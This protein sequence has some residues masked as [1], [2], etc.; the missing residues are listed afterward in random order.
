MLKREAGRDQTCHF[1]AAAVDL[2]LE[3]RSPLCALMKHGGSNLPEQE[4]KNALALLGIT[5]TFSSSLLLFPSSSQYPQSWASPAAVTSTPTP[6]QNCSSDR[7]HGLRLCSPCYQ[8]ATQCQHLPWYKT[9]SGDSPVCLYQICCFTK[10][11]RCCNPPRARHKA[12]RVLCQQRGDR[13][14][15][16]LQ[17]K[18]LR[19]P[20][21]VKTQPGN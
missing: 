18:V 15:G 8:A 21:V 4:G 7:V 3:M 11:S 9:T 14:A 16:S 2:S 6:P 13:L 20:D 5:H 10:Y 12:M 1:S 17:G 19:A